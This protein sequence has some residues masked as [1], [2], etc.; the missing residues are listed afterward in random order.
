MGDL[1][2]I[3][4]SM[5]S[6]FLECSRCFYLQLNKKIDR[7]KG[8]F[9]SLTR[10]MDG[11]IKSFYDLYRREGKLPPEIE[12]KVIGKLLDDEQLLRK[13]R[14]N[15]VGIEFLDKKINAILKGAIDDCLINKDV[16]IPVD[17]KTRGYELKDDSTSYY[18]R[19]LDLYCYLLV[20]NGYK[21]ADFAYLIFYYPKLVK[22]NG[23]VSFE[24][25]P[26]KVSTD[27]NRAERVFHESVECLRGPEP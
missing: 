9:P 16:Y 19:Q 1:I 6:L 11:V 3:T 18:E 23:L 26:I 25:I 27:I 13:W 10:G 21:V 4:P 14:N 15:R 7:P 8:I 17:Y 24:V 20:K 2:K 22:E 5:I 12:G